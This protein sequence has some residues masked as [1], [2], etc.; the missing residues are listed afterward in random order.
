MNGLSPLMQR[1]KTKNELKSSRSSSVV[2]LNTNIQDYIIM[3]MELFVP[4]V[5]VKVQKNYLMMNV[6][7]NVVIVE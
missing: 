5:T 4:I 2:G 7:T 6:F 1:A 3:V